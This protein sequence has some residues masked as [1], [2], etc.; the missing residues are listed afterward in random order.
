[1]IKATDAGDFLDQ[2]RSAVN[3]AAPWR[4]GHIK[5]A[6]RCANGKAKRFQD[7]LLLGRLDDHARQAFNLAGREDYAALPV[8]ARPHG[9]RHRRFAAADLGDH[10]RDM[11]CRPD[12]AFGIKSALKPVA[13]IGVEVQ[14]AASARSSTPSASPMVIMPASIS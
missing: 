7:A 11:S 9:D 3:I 2:I 5:A 6:I 13:R 10:P 12:R 1:M 8:N 4:R 14:L